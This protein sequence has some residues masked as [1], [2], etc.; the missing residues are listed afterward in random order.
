MSA[1]LTNYSSKNIDKLINSYPESNFFNIIDYL[2]KK[3]NVN[4]TSLLIF[5]LYFLSGCDCF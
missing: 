1:E 4:K 3:F 5:N 2:S